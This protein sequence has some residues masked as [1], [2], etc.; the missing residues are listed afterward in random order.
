MQAAVMAIHMLV[1]VGLLLLLY[2]F[3]LCPNCLV[4]P[5]VLPSAP[6]CI[7]CWRTGNAFAQPVSD[8]VLASSGALLRQQHCRAGPGYLLLATL[9]WYLEICFCCQEIYYC[10]HT[11]ISSKQTKSCCIC[12]CC[13]LFMDGRC[14][15]WSLTERNSIA[16]LQLFGSGVKLCIYF[17][18]MEFVGFVWVW[19]SA[20][21]W[22]TVV[23]SVHCFCGAICAL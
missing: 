8:W 18:Q 14:Q 10:N 6:G 5:C 2:I 16:V 20:S 1:G 7:P 15:D 19:R 21:D 17:F 4:F 12:F 3:Y 22:V 11:N 9:D 13:C 23:A